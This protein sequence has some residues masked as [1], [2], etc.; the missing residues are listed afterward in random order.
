MIKDW[1][2]A[3]PA[4]IKLAYLPNYGMVRLRLTGTGDKETVEQELDKQFTLLKELV[5]E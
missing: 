2:E 5:K 3:L 4:Y 1:E